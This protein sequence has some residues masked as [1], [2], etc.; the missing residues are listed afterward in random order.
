MNHRSTREAA[1]K[2]GLSLMTIQR[3][4]ADRKFDAPP[5]QRVGGV[6]VRLWSDKDIE[7]IRKILPK[8]ANGRKTRYKKKGSKTA[9]KK[10]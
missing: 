2:L 10:R 6:R 7:R 8:I 5:L 4:I 1:K 3:Y 9:N